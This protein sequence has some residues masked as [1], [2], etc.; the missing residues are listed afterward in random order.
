MLHKKQYLYKN[1]YLKN[2]T[3]NIKLKNLNTFVI[4]V[5]MWHA[6]VCI[7]RLLV[8]KKSDHSY[9]LCRKSSNKKIVW[10][11]S[12]KNNVYWLMLHL[13]FLW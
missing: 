3:T 2:D 12:I 6:A 4:F 10:Y 13:K 1:C 5:Y 8:Q 9:K 7:R 11:H